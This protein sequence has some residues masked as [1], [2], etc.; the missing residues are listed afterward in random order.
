MVERGRRKNV[1]IYALCAVLIFA[2]A[3]FI[4]CAT[5]SM[6]YINAP[7]QVEATVGK[8]V[9]PVYKVV[10]KDGN[11]LSG[12]TVTLMSVTDADGNALTVTNGSVTVTK[13][14]T[15]TFVYTAGGGKVSDARVKVVFTEESNQLPPEE[16]TEEPLFV[17]SAESVQTLSS[18][19]NA[20]SFDTNKKYGTE[21][22]SLKVVTNSNDVAVLLPKYD[23]TD[24]DYV[25][26]YVYTNDTSFIAGTQWAGDTVLLPGNWTRV[27]IHLGLFA[28]CLRDDSIQPFWPNGTDKDKKPE[29][30]LAIRFMRQSEGGGTFYVSS[31]TLKKYTRKYSENQVSA[32]AY[33][34]TV[35]T[36]RFATLEYDDNKKVTVDDPNVTERGSLKVTVGDVDGNHNEVYLSTDAVMIGDLQAYKEVYFYVYTTVADT[37]AGTWWCSD[38]N[39]VP[40]QWTK[41]TVAKD[42]GGLTCVEG[43]G[44]S[45]FKDGASRF[46]YRLAA[47][48]KKPALQKGQVFWVSSLYGVLA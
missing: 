16:P 35:I 13:A 44:K 32:I 12:Y 17:P 3:S 11:E 19:G 39:L 22:G 8:Y 1:L 30:K 33:A 37:F 27:Q 29:G 42:D 5:I 23:Y 38:E 10:D 7:A 15:Y 28:L 36:S 9:S 6:G 4:S 18:G 21:S 34:R 26:F 48:Q 20:V 47:P 45:P 40:G 31:L 14:G 41:V 25:E 43:G 24:Y 2:S 46:V